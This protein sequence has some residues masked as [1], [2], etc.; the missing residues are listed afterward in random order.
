MSSLD[1]SGSTLFAGLVFSTLGGVAWVYGK[2]TQ[3]A[4]PMVLGA[5]LV[6]APFVLDGI[7]LWAIGAALTLFVFW[8]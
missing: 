2:K 6:G 7:S 4:R 8:P 5:A 1:L 3:T